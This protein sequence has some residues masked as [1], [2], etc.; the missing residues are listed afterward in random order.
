MKKCAIYARVAAEWNQHY[1][2]A[3]TRKLTLDE[4]VEAF[5]VSEKALKI[6]GGGMA[7]CPVFNVT[8]FFVPEELPD[9]CFIHADKDEDAHVGG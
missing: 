9:G 6:V 1:A 8:Y 3:D 7:C 5:P 2:S 4:L